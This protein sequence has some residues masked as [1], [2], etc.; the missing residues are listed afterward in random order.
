MPPEKIDG[1]LG[2]AD[3]EALGSR[4]AMLLTSYFSIGIEKR[5]NVR[6]TIR[7]KLQLVDFVCLVEAAQ[8][9][10]LPRCQ[11]VMMR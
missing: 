10:M 3:G 6:I 7:K 9:K 11:S 8:F 5:L 4:I 1:I 2:V